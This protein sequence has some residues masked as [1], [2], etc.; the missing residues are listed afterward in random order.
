M[1]MTPAFYS[2]GPEWNGSSRWLVDVDLHCPSR[3]SSRPREK[4]K[5]NAG[6]ASVHL[7]SFVSVCLSH[8]CGK[9]YV[10]AR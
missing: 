3:T 10:Q 7:V 6:K 2:P 4:G 8:T 5:R 1:S 9:A